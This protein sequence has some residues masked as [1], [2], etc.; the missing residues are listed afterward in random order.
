MTLMIISYLKMLTLLYMHPNKILLYFH[1][2][3]TIDREKLD[4]LMSELL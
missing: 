1:I 4:I 2:S 3:I